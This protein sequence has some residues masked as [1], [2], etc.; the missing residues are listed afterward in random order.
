MIVNIALTEL[1]CFPNIEN[2]SLGSSYLYILNQGAGIC[3]YIRNYIKYITLDVSENCVE[4]YI[5]LCAVQMDTKSSHIVI[6]CIYKS[7]QGNTANFL[8]CGDANINHSLGSYR[9]TQLIAL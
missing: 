6:I 9:K 2:Y 8:I 3:I 5:E 4:K 7:T 1:Y